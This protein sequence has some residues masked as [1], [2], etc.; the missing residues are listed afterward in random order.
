M[1][2]NQRFYRIS[3]IFAVLG[4]DEIAITDINVA[5]QTAGWTPG[6]PNS[7]FTDADCATLANAYTA[8]VGTTG[9]RWAD[10]SS[11]TGLKVAAINLDGSYIYDP[12]V[13]TDV[14]PVHGGTSDIAVPSTIAVSLFAAGSLGAGNRG[15]MY[16][17]HTSFATIASRPFAVASVATALAAAGVTFVH[18]V[19]TVVAGYTGAPVVSVMSQAGSGSHKPVT[20]VRVGNVVD[21]QRRRRN[22][23]QEAYSEAAV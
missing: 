8:M 3:W 14:S 11:L 18:A 15:R 21:T 19:N 2:Y 20:R 9:V 10:Y 23:L 4:S 22:R 5:S 17:P 16:L 13:Y 12:K 1:A 6:D 7:N